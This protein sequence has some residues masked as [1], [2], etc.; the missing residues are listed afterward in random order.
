MPH[1]SLGFSPLVFMVFSDFI[2]VVDDN[3]TW[4]EHITYI[5]NKISKNLGILYKM[6][7]IIDRKSLTQLYF[8][9]INSYLSYGN[10]IWASTHKTKLQPLHNIQKHAAR[11]IF[12]ESKFAH[13]KPLLE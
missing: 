12:F 13:S 4:K 11:I 10:I 6:R 7:H 9:F 1:F 2:P 5:K 8:S 3:F